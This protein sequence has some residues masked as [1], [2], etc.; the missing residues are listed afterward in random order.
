MTRRKHPPQQ[1]I[2]AIIARDR[3]MSYEDVLTTFEITPNQLY[4][5]VTRDLED[6]IR[7]AEG[8][9]RRPL[10]QISADSERKREL[11]NM[12][13]AFV[14]AQYDRIQGKIPGE[15]QRRIYNGTYTHPFNVETLVY[16]ALTQDNPPLS[17][18]DRIV[19]V[20][21]IQG[22]PTNLKKYFHQLGLGSLMVSAFEK[23]QRGSPLAVLEVFDRVYQRITGDAS[24]FDLTQEQHLHRWGDTFRAP[25]GYWRDQANVEEAVYHT[26]IEAQPELV[27][28]DRV[29]IVGTIQGLPTNLQKYFHQ[30]GL[31]GLMVSAFEKGQQD[32]P[33]TVLE[34]FDRVYQAKT[35][36]VSL[37]DQSKPMYLAVDGGWRIIRAA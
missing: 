7:Y 6:L 34:V 16:Y 23:G 30:L 32:S 9:E 18:H 19:V 2:E 8:S 31:A 15:K 14:C 27:S 21:T 26:L 35:G 12:G 29:T 36:D 5:A 10:E 33:L 37:F 13:E 17:S 20:G 11:F 1:F 25:Q 28:S 22:L 24:L 3:G 4:R